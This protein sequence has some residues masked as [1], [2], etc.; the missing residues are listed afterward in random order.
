MSAACVM[1]GVLGQAADSLSI[2][3]QHRFDLMLVL[4]ISVLSVA[5]IICLVAMLMVIQVTRSAR[6]AHER[7]LPNTRLL[8]LER[9]FYPPV[10]AVP[11]RWLA[12]RSEN[13][14]AVQSA[15]EI[16]RASCRE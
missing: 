10:F 6:V 3:G 13:P 12:V 16:G 5:V 4:L 8:A 2:D 14:Q 15:L 1:L 11:N 7:A 9:R